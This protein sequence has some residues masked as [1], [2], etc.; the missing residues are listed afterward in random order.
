MIQLKFKEKGNEEF[1][2]KPL[3]SLSTVLNSSK[4]YFFNINSM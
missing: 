2:S 3:K 1:I 4:S